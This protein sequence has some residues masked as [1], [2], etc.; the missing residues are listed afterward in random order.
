LADFLIKPLLYRLGE[1]GTV[2][3]PVGFL[4]VFDPGDKRIYQTVVAVMG[5]QSGKLPA[6][7]LEGKGGL[8]DAVEIG[9]KDRLVENDV[10]L[11]TPDG[12]FRGG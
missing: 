11:F 6:P 7:Y 1:G 5:R 10:S 3:G 4:S 8:Y 12:I 9:G 2:K